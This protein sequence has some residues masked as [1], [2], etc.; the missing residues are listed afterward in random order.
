MAGQSGGWDTEAGQAALE[1]AQEIEVKDDLLNRAV[2]ILR[3]LQDQEHMVAVLEEAFTEQMASY[4]TSLLKESSINV[5]LRDFEASDVGEVD[6]EVGVGAVIPPELHSLITKG[7][8]NSTDAFYAGGSQRKTDA[9]A[10]SHFR[11]RNTQVEGVIQ[12]MARLRNQKVCPL[13]LLQD[14][15]ER[16]YNGTSRRDWIFQARSRIVLT[17]TTTW[18]MIK[19][20][21][22]VWKPRAPYEASQ[23]M[24]VSGQD[25]KEWYRS[26]KFTGVDLEGKKIDNELFHTVTGEDIPVPASIACDGMDGDFKNS[27]NWPFEFKFDLREAIPSP[28]LMKETLQKTLRE[29]LMLVKIDPIGM[30]RR[31]PPEADCWPDRPPTPHFHADL[32]MNCGTSSYRD[33]AKI[34]ERCRDGAPA[35]KRLIF[36]DFQTGDRLWGLKFGQRSEHNDIC[37]VLGEFHAHAH[38]VDGV[39]HLEWNYNIQHW[40]IIFNV[41]GLGQKLIMKEYDTRYHWLMKI[42]TAG[43]LWLLDLGFTDAELCDF[44]GILKLVEKN[45]PVWAFVGMVFYQI[46]PLWGWKT[47]TQCYN[48]DY[49][50]TMWKWC[51][52]LYA[53]TNKHNYKKA[54]VM[55]SRVLFDTCPSVQATLSHCRTAN[56]RG[57]PCTAQAIDMLIEKVSPLRPESLLTH[58]LSTFMVD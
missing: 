4:T 43:I 50:N 29:A 15:L 11:K 33:C 19:A 47:A 22:A 8:W 54:A 18:K 44:D 28:S 27:E 52:L 5:L 53:N 13:Y 36:G 20:V 1:L 37:P 25:N 6:S 55:M 30:L 34:I 46:L 23:Y 7:I 35:S 41:R 56:V 26:V 51:H 9:Q 49:M 2:G 40:G 12:H 24:A 42:G 57:R 16:A 48:V 38:A 10:V 39:F 17:P 31:P 58:T 21:K 45:T 3:R 32:L 14:S